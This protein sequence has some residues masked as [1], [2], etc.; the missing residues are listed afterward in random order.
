MR[1]PTWGPIV[2]QRVKDFLKALVSEANH[3]YEGSDLLFRWED[4]SRPKLVVETKRRYLEKLTDLNRNQIYE[5]I[6]ILK[7]LDILDDNRTKTQGKD[8]WYFTLKL[9]SQDPLR[10]MAFFEKTWES[11]RSARS[12]THPQYLPGNKFIDTFT[13]SHSPIPIA[14][15]LGCGSYSYNI[16]PGY[17]KH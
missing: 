2:K 12:K 6:Q 1:K 13:F 8:D 4:S 15:S 3:F 14:L 9:W 16:P 11:Q 17:L 10:N 7:I 5:V